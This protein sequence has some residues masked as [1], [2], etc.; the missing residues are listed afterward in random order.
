MAIDFGVLFERLGRL[1]HVA[2]LVHTH[3]ATIPDALE[4]L[5]DDYDGITPGTGLRD[6]VAPVIALDDAITYVAGTFL[7][8]IQ[9]AAVQTLLRMVE[10]DQPY[11]A[12]SVE[13]ALVE[14]RRQMLVA[15][16]TV[17]RSVVSVAATALAGNSGTGQVVVTTTGG[18]GL[19]LEL[20]VAE[21]GKLFCEES[22]YTGD[23]VAGAEGFRWLGEVADLSD[24]WR[25]DWPAGSNSSAAYTSV[26]P[27]STDTR[28]VNGGFESFAVANVPDGWVIA[29]GTAG[30][31]VLQDLVV[32]WTGV[33]SLKLV[34]AAT[35]TSLTQAFGQDDEADGS[36]DTPTA[37]T[38]YG[39]SFWVRVTTVPAAG[40]LTCDLID[41]TGAVVADAQG[42]NNTFTRVITTLV[43]LTWTAVQGVFRLPK[44]I[45]AGLKIRLR[46]STAMTAGSSLNIDQLT[47]AELAEPYPGGP[48]IGVF[49]G[50]TGWAE[51]D[52]YTLAVANDRG[53]GLYG[54]TFQTVFERFY[55]MTNFGL[56]LPST[57]SGGETQ[58]DTLITA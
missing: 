17:L 4:D 29:A 30:T 54:A 19:P 34:G 41:G 46:L 20:V 27:D 13:D 25:Y 6:V 44:A 49:S 1:G 42:V 33:S 28:V 31:E 3:E 16:E 11:A 18:D 10:N 36:T 12:G 48:L 47:L 56:L 51:L 39:V 58:P 38:A 2:Y 40:V 26:D 45:P 24:V 23:A 8:V 50:A 53:G 57:T 9:E 22:S 43:N 35:N 32:F 15:G 7:P 5:Y 21:T 55:G 52:G 37:L 14:L